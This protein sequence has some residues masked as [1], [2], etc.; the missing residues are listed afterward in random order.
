M[1]TVKQSIAE[2]SLWELC[3]R[4]C[5]AYPALLNA[6]KRITAYAE[7]IEKYDPVTKRPFFYLGTTSAHR[8]E[9]LRY[10]YRLNRFKLSG[11]VLITATE[12]KKPKSKSK[13]EELENENYNYDHLFF[14]KP[15]FGP[16]P[17]ELKESY[18]V[19]QSEIPTEVDSEA[20]TVALQNVLK[21]LKLNEGKAKFVFLYDD[22]S[23]E[24][25]LIAEIGEYAEVRKR[26]VS[27]QNSV[28]L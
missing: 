6:L 18:P 8:P 20:K 15:P 9:V 5:R 19:G 4:R 10:S 23:W 22:R 13:E 27:A 21:L 28:D 16:C 7:L 12:T 24:H 25:P 11:N 1:R 17:V 14:V 2:G 3:E 26:N